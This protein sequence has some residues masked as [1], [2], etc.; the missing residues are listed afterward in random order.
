M[1]N[2]IDIEWSILDRIVSFNWIFERVFGKYIWDLAED[3]EISNCKHIVKN[4]FWYYDAEKIIV[5]K[6]SFNK[7]KD[8]AKIVFRF[9]EQ[10]T[11]PI[12]K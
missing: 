12:I 1:W 6:A 11:N 3:P 10:P 7:I 8:L 5:N 4:I 9:V 2:K